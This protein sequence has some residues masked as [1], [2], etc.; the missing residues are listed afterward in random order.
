MPSKK[1]DVL[2]DDQGLSIM[3]DWFTPMAYFF[4]FFTLFWN[5]ILY[6][7]IQNLWF[8]SNASFIAKLAPIFHVL[9]GLGLIYHV[10]S[11][12]L[13][14]SFIEVSDGL[15]K[16]HHEPIPHY[17]KKK[18]IELE[19]IK[20]LYVKEKI[21]KTKNGVQRSYELRAILEEH[22]D[23]KLIK[24][25]GLQSQDLF[26]LEKVLEEYIGIVDQPVKGEYGS[27]VYQ[28]NVEKLDLLT[29]PQRSKVKTPLVNRSND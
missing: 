6:F 12:F 3:I 8:G 16:I 13:N 19:T 5:G 28:L 17:L 20:Q 4:L 21:S 11:L 18:S 15:L 2:K 25:A 27:K 29:N 10:A 23:I 22:Q 14:K 7:L 1:I 24:I 26:Q 9:V